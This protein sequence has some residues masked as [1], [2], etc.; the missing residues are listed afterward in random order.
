MLESGSCLWRHKSGHSEHADDIWCYGHGW[1][2]KLIHGQNRSLDSHPSLLKTFS[3]SRL[4]SQLMAPSTQLC[5]LKT[6]NFHSCLSSY[7]PISDPSA[8]SDSSASKM[9]PQS[10]QA[11]PSTLLPTQ[12][13]SPPSLLNSSNNLQT[14]PPLPPFPPWPIP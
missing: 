4:P 9:C 14:V 10:V 2:H 5:R 11:S 12:P 13:G 3:S 8:S 7:I 1:D 6:Q